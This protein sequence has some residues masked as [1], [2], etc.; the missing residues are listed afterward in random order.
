MDRWWTSWKGRT[1]T[2]TADYLNQSNITSRHRKPLIG[3]ERLCLCRN[4]GWRNGRRYAKSVGD[5]DW[6]GGNTD[7]YWM[8]LEEPHP[9]A[10][11]LWYVRRGKDGLWSKARLTGEIFLRRVW[12][13]YARVEYMLTY[14]IWNDPFI[15][16]NHTPGQWTTEMKWTQ[17]FFGQGPSRS[18]AGENSFEEFRIY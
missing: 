3:I 17:V 6:D 7:W 5:E 11:R 14:N 9:R 13:L 10:Y 12:P 1:Q 18:R 2:K 8:D 15:T 4:R 16:I